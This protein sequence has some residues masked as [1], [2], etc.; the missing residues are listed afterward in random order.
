MRNTGAVGLVIGLLVV[1]L[2]S[3]CGGNKGRKKVDYDSAR[4]LPPLEIPPGLSTLPQ[5]SSVQSGTATYSEFEAQQQQG[6][7]EQF[8]GLLPTFGNVK[9]ERAGTQRWLVV[10]AEA[11]KLWPQMRD[12]IDSVGLRVVKERPEA[13][14]LESDW[15]EN[16]VNIG[17]GIGGVSRQAEWRGWFGSYGQVSYPTRTRRGT[18]DDGGLLEPSRYAT[19]SSDF[20]SGSECPAK[21]ERHPIPM[22]AAPV[23]PRARSGNAAPTH[24]AHW[25][26]GAAGGCRARCRATAGAS[27]YGA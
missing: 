20:W 17:G 21:R 9:L 13:G 18:G 7:K 14:I 8:A 22:E 11:E 25:G 12:F 2:A 26:D 15:A 4:T 1:A 27:D 6:S 24:V 23:G 19:D 16:R 3:G 10:K 5:S